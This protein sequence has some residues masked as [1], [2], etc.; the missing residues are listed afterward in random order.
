MTAKPEI[1]T[2][3]AAFAAGWRCERHLQSWTL[4][5][6]GDG[7]D[8]RIAIEYLA[9][10]NFLVIGHGDTTLRGQSELIELLP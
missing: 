7:G 6:T 5:V 4:N 2:V 9:P 1:R 10:S 3:E 8:N